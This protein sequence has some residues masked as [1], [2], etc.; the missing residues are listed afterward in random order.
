M[1]MSFPDT[2]SFK[3]YLHLADQG[4]LNSCTNLVPI[5]PLITAACEGQGVGLKRVRKTGYVSEPDQ[6]T[7]TRNI[8][9]NTRIT[10]KTDVTAVKYLIFISQSSKKDKKILLGLPHTHKITMKCTSFTLAAMKFAIFAFTIALKI[11]ILTRRP[12]FKC[13]FKDTNSVL[14]WIYWSFTHFLNK[15]YKKP[16]NVYRFSDTYPGR[17]RSGYVYTERNFQP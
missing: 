1:I 4:F 11:N 9:R 6:Y 8:T 7:Y 17:T 15:M 14:E 2:P 10:C 13:Y 3:Y 16:C 12:T 5:G